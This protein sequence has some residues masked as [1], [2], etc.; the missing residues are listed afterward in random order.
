MSRFAPNELIAVDAVLSRPHVP[1]RGATAFGVHG[2]MGVARKLLVNQ[3]TVYIAPLEAPIK[4]AA[5]G[6]GRHLRRRAD[7]GVKS[8]SRRA[9]NTVTE[10]KH[11]QEG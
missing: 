7:G 2:S 11:R 5:T 3:H 10:P 6:R 9:Q 4:A 8:T 1:I